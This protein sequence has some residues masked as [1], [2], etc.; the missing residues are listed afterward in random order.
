MAVTE[1]ERSIREVFA[2][3][4]RV[5]SGFEVRPQQTAMAEAISRSLAANESLIVEAPT[6]VGKTMAYLVPSILEAVSNERKAVIST[7]TKNLQ[8]QLLHNDIPLARRLLQVPFSA[9]V[10][11]GRFNYLC[12]TRLAAALES[13]GRLFSSPE[14]EELDRLLAWAHATTDGDLESLP[15][16]PSPSVLAMVRS[17][18]GIC[19]PRNCRN[20][21]FYQRSRE[22]AREADLVIMNHALFFQ[23]M[24]RG[25]EEDRLIFEND[26]VVFDEAHT[27]EQAASAALGLRVSNVQVRALVSRLYHPRTRRGFFAKRKRTFADRARR[28]YT[29][30]DDFFHDAFSRASATSAEKAREIRIRSPHLVANTLSP[31]LQHLKKAAEEV[32]S[33]S[34]DAPAKELKR[35]ALELDQTD[36]A[37][38]QFLDQS[39]EA[40]AYWIEGGTGKEQAVTFCA[41]PWDVSGIL[42]PKLFGGRTSVILTS[43]TITTQGSPRY[44]QSRLGA[45]EVPFRL[46]DSPF[47]YH[48]Q[49][50]IAVAPDA[51]PPDRPAEYASALPARILQA[52]QRSKGKALVLFTSIAQLQAVASALREPLER[53]GIHLLV[54]HRGDQRHHLLEEFK[55]DVHSVLFG[56]DSF[57]MGVDVPGEA[58]QHVIITRLPFAV[59]NHPLVEARIESIEERGGS[60]FMEYSL[61]EAVLKFRQGA[62]RLIRNASD[63]GIITILDSRIATKS[64]GRVFIESL[65]RCPLELVYKNGEIS[66]DSEDSMSSP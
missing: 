59:P 63:T 29:E 64:Y 62:G 15:F 26:F 8:D 37:L 56:V 23:L 45:L 3:A 65:P 20:S 41:S 27:I 1:E 21:C 48:R 25:E 61:P 13:A 40:C 10:M 57:W 46:L 50:R 33:D 4:P 24:Q 6:G 9:V 17:E 30:I 11:K 39:L 16:V 66:S 43:A 49:M 32:A 2:S 34:E 22:Q 28:A 7:H 52:I 55:R 51:P 18:P 14:Q 54:Q 19:N 12:T 58:L 47:D 42:G 53:D 60:P 38:T 35:L 36:D 31:T 5:W 44:F